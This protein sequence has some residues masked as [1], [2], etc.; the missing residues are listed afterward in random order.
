MTFVSLQVTLVGLAVLVVQNAFLHPTPLLPLRL[1][2][3][4]PPLPPAPV[5]PLPPDPHHYLLLYTTT[6]YSSTPTTSY[7][8]T[9]TTSYSSTPTTTSSLQYPHYLLLQCPHYL[10]QV[11]L[12]VLQIFLLL[13]EIDFHPVL[14]KFLDPMGPNLLH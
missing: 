12:Q 7:S 6:S 10:L 4:P 2:P 3:V 13:D 1:A 14:Y 9:P 11:F 5:P 8:S